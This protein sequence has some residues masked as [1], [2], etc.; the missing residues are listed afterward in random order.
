MY[1]PVVCQLCAKEIKAKKILLCSK[2]KLE[3]EVEYFHLKKQAEKFYR[4]DKPELI[5]N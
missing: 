3:I 2:C 1:D 4:K 5:W